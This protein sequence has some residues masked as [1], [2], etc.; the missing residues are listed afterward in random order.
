[1]VEMHKEVPGKRF[2][3][4][5]ELG[6]HAFGEKM[7]LW[8]VVP[9][10]LMVE[11]GVNIVYMITGG[12]S[13]KKIHDLACHDCKPIK[14]TYFIMIFASVHFFLSNLPSFNSITLVS[15]AAAV[16]SL[17][18][19]TI[20]WVASAHKGVVPD[21]SYGHRATTTAGNVFNFLSALGDVAFE[22]AGH[23]VVLEIQA[24]IPSTPDCPSNRNFHHPRLSGNP[25]MTMDW[26]GAPA[27]PSSFTVK[28]ILRL[29]IPVDTYLNFNFVGRLLGL[30][31]N[32]LKWVEATTGCRVCI[33]GKGSIKDPEKE[34]KLRGRLGYEHLNEPLHVLIEAD[35]PANII[36]IRLRQA[37][38]IIEELLKPV[39][40]EVISG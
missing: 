1:M 7:G 19:S 11:I 35:L 28:R 33:R 37:Q 31:G 21:V 14:T 6:Q 4:Y 29:E 2:D 39:I 34:E 36:D 20:A 5:H 27:S 17:S 32:S 8:V 12:N 38:E 25:R 40:I 9:Q 18:Y 30:R 23:N 13:L 24:T 22:F 26:Q 3:R 15:L 16:M 10:Q